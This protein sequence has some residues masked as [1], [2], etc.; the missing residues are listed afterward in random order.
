MGHT[1]STRD[2]EGFRTDEITPH[3][4]KRAVFR[5]LFRPAFPN[6]DSR[7]IECLNLPPVPFQ[8]PSSEISLP[9]MSPQLSVI[10]MPICCTSAMVLLSTKKA[11][12]PSLYASCYLHPTATGLGHE[13]LGWGSIFSS[14]RIDNEESHAES[15]LESTAA[16]V[17]HMGNRVSVFWGLGLSDEIVQAWGKHK[18]P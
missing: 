17:A 10:F 4:Q 1:P 5:G 18:R 6:Y 2:S 14:D 9:A 12:I 15:A 7:L 13:V 8:V 11:R 16:M 3:R